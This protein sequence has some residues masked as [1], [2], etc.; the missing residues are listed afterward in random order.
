MISNCP[1]YLPIIFT[2]LL[3]L[4]IITSF[5]I[6][7]SKSDV[8]P[9]FPT[10]SDTAT[11]SPESNIFSELVNIATFLGVIVIYMRYLQVK[12]DVEWVEGSRKIFVA[13]RICVV[14]GFIAICGSSL[15]ANFPETQVTT[16]HLIG[17]FLLF[18]SGNIYAWIQVWISFKMKEIGLVG[19]HICFIRL[20]LSVISTLSF[21]A[22]LVLMKFAY[23]DHNKGIVLRWHSD[24]SGFKEHIAA[25]A[26]E[27]VMVGSF[28]LVFLTF[29]KELENS[30]LQVRLVRSE[31]RYESLTNQ[32]ENNV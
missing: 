26:M 27:W 13:N 31:D 21:L 25:D 17:A 15:V 2:L 4:S 20:V 5:L 14:L 28:L 32:T 8:T 6:A 30:R 12:R 19:S 1:Q 22:M 10:I 29:T 23:K 24:E 3:T 7:V 16:V 18:C 9:W 11:K